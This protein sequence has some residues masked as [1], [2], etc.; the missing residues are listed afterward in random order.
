MGIRILLF[1][2]CLLFYGAGFI[3]LDHRFQGRAVQL[4]S[5]P[6]LKLLQVTS[7]YLKQITAAM[8]FIRTSVFLGGVQA[9][10]DPQEY[11]TVLAQNLKTMTSLYPEFK[12]PYFFTQSF[13]APISVASAEEANAILKKAIETL[14][15]NFIFRFFHAFNYY[16]FLDKPLLAA[17]A[18]EEA[19]KL[20]DAPP[21]FARLAA[22]F[23]AR[24]GDLSGGLIMLRLMVK[25]E[26]NET[27]KKRYLEE[28]ELLEKAIIVEK[29]IAAY[30]K[31]HKR[32][33]AQLEHLVP[34]YLPYLPVIKG[35]FIMEYTPPYLYLKRP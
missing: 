11:E 3:W 19:A 5:P 32:P 29:A 16:N 20:E 6:P 8:L 18:F 28:I 12:D 4:Q 33:P 10:V 25:G 17:K 15:H 9:G 13:L 26:T 22:I 31:D 27:L 14:P 7:G 30:K 1:L 35:R 21:M 24:G 23:S 34:G 2:F